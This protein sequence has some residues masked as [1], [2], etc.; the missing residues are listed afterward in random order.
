MERTTR[1]LLIVL[2]ALLLLDRFLPAG[3]SRTDRA[4]LKR[5]DEGREKTEQSISRLEQANEKLHDMEQGMK[6]YLAYVRDIQGRVEILDLER[7]IREA[8]FQS[9]SDSLKT[10][11]KKLY[12][13]IE[14][15][16]SELPRIPVVDLKNEDL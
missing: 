16:G 11:L 2:C 15:T 9:Q 7:R 1:Y 12:Q 14:M 13:E 3:C 10:R 6:Q 8:R 4:I 5:L